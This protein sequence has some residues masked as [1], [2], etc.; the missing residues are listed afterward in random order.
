MDKSRRLMRISLVVALVWSGF[1]VVY[2]V[3][4]DPHAWMVWTGIA[5]SVLYLGLAWDHCRRSRKSAHAAYS[6]ETSDDPTP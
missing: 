1:L 6:D 2:I 5:I 4:R 3:L